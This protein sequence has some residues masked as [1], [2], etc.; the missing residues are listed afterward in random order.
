MIAANWNHSRKCDCAL[1]EN[2]QLCGSRADI[3]QTDSELSFV[4][5]QHRIGCCQR[6]ESRIV[7]VNARAIHGR[8]YVLHRAG[9][10]RNQMDSHLKA[11][12]HHAQRIV[13]AGLIVQNEFLGKQVQHFTTGG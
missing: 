8:N 4:G 13:H 2:N 7:H 6:L 9:R 1:Q 3:G 12:R 11:R 5:T 10:R